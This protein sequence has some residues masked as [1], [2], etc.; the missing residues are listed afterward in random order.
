MPRFGVV[1]PADFAP[2]TAAYEGG[3][4]ALCEI[5]AKGEA[6]LEYQVGV[7]CDRSLCQVAVCCDR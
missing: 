3:D 6:V 5:M 7:C 4:T 1:A 2:W